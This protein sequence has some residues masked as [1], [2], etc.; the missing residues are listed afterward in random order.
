MRGREGGREEG[1]GVGEELARK[2]GREERTEGQRERGR[3][4]E[5]DKGRE[6]E[7][8]SVPTMV[9][10]TQIDIQ[11]HDR[12]KAFTEYKSLHF[13]SPVLVFPP[14][15]C[16]SLLPPSLPPSLPR[17][18]TVQVLPPESSEATLSPFG[19]TLTFV[20]GTFSSDWM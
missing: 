15:P 8:W 17:A 19:S 3:G 4:G 10:T 20:S 9:L 11:V 18:L 5:G 6:R 16:L 14:P 13:P 12:T 2:R 7:G 1:G